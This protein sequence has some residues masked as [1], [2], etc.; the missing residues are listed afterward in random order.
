MQLDGDTII[1]DANISKEEVLEF[2]EFIRPRIEYIETIEV[3]Q[4]DEISSSTLIS[5][6]VSIKKSYPQIEISFLDKKYTSPLYGIIN[7][8]YHD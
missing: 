2:E 8:I 4:K 6:L 7:W 3:E 5:L 1:I